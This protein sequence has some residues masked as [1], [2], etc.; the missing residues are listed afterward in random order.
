MNPREPVTLRAEG[1]VL[2][3]NGHRA[4]NDVSLAPMPGAWTA[5]AGP[6][7][8]GKSTLL[9]VMAGLQKPQA[10]RVNLQ[11][12][13]IEAW[14]PQERALRVAWLGQHAA[15]DADLEVSEVVMLGRIPHLGLHGLPT[16]DDRHAVMQAMRSTRCDAFVGRR[17]SALSGGERQRVLLARVLATQAS[18]MLLDE[19][20]THLD[21][22]HQRLL[23]TTLRERVAE[24]ATVVSVVHDLNLALAADRLAVLRAGCLLVE[25]NPAQ[26][27]VRQGLIEAFEGAISVVP[28]EAGRRWIAFNRE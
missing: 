21:A 20:S 19:P 17:L 3:R 22:P 27:T 16:E 11:G 14:R 7:G 23:T 2:E 5:I 9:R 4:L 13:A 1:L 8:A 25:G 18:I 6:N 12:R 28:V 15:A 24:G 26:A 10:G